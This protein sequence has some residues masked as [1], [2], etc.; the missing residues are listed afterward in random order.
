MSLKGY[1]AQAF[2]ALTP[3]QLS[4]LE[5]YGFQ[6]RRLGFGSS[7]TVVVYPPFTSVELFS[8][9]TEEIAEDFGGGA[10]DVY[11]H[12]PLCEYPC[13]FC[14]YATKQV[15]G[16]KV[17]A[18]DVRFIDFILEEARFWQDKLSALGNP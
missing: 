13:T 6:R 18:S 10:V 9:S 8:K 5:Q 17:P 12:V 14:H 16:E 1:Y 2:D 3:K 4:A 7:H 11:L 15:P